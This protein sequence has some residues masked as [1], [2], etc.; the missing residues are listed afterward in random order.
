MRVEAETKPD[1]DQPGA[2]T[3]PEAETKLEAEPEVDTTYI[4]AR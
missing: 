1:V 3:K 2:E 4:C